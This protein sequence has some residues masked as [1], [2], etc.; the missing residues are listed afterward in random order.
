MAVAR[1]HVQQI[2]EWAK[3]RDAT[4]WGNANDGYWV[5]DP[6]PIWDSTYKYKIIYPQYL[7]A[8]RWYLTDRLEVKSIPH[9]TSWHRVQY[10]PSGNYTP[11]FQYSPDQYRK[12]EPSPYK[13]II[14]GPDGEV[15]P[16]D[17]SDED[18]AKL[19]KSQ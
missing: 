11:S 13:I 6:L 1:K 18:W 8:W 7:E 16:S 15:N 14:V 2:I 5:R 3:N 12:W 17:L 19:R 4:V 10:D 9:S